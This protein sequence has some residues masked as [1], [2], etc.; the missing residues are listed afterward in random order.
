MGN[1]FILLFDELEK[2]VSL[3]EKFE[4][5]KSLEEAFEIVQPHLAGISFEQFQKFL[6]FILDKE[7][8]NFKKIDD[9]E[10]ESIVGGMGLKEVIKYFENSKKI[11]SLALTSMLVVGGILNTTSA[12]ITNGDNN[13][14][15]IPKIKQVSF[16]NRVKVLNDYKENEDP[17]F[18][19]LNTTERTIENRKPNVS[20]VLLNDRKV[21]FKKMKDSQVFKNIKAAKNAMEYLKAKDKYMKTFGENQYSDYGVISESD[22]QNNLFA[23]VDLIEDILFE[24]N[25]FMDEDEK[26][27]WQDELSKL[28]E[29]IQTIEKDFSYERFQVLKTLSK[30]RKAL[31]KN[32]WRSRLEELK[33]MFVVEDSNDDIDMDILIKMFNGI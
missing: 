18:E 32:N 29:A 10:L 11:A 7:S 30:L 19:K 5:S 33:N 4:N 21:D 26:I 13:N 14:N 17:V 31:E 16:N 8:S 9:S 3:R 25:E 24:Y 15:D 1:K 27:Y 2:N 22:K 28:N 20:K 23:Q 12:M 6:V